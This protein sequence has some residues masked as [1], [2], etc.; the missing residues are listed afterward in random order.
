MT[1]G[2]NDEVVLY[3]NWIILSRVNFKK[4]KNDEVPS[5]IEEKMMHDCNIEKKKKNNTDIKRKEKSKKKWTNIERRNQ[6]K[7]SSHNLEA[8]CI[9]SYSFI[10]ILI[11]YY[12]YIYRYLIKYSVIDYI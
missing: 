8:H 4:I 9:L 1:V 12:E 3:L 5:K 7:I 2:W 11:I 6:I 10:S